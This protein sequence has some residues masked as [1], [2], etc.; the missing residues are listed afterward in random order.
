MPGEAPSNDQIQEG[1][2]TAL[3]SIQNFVEGRGGK[4]EPSAA[5]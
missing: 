3:Q 4:E 5:T 1:I 2:D